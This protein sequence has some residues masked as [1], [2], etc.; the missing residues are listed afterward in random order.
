MM[1]PDRISTASGQESQGYICIRISSN[2]R[3][4]ISNLD[5]SNNLFETV[6]WKPE[7]DE[8]IPQENSDQ[9]QLISYVPPQP[10]YIRQLKIKPNP[11]KVKFSKSRTCCKNASWNFEDFYWT[12]EL[13]K[14]QLL[15]THQICV[16]WLVLLIKLHTCREVFNSS[17]KILELEIDNSCIDT[18]LKWSLVFHRSITIIDALKLD[19]ILILLDIYALELHLSV[20]SRWYNCIG[21]P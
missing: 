16:C 21:T 13:V 6:L 10:F 5:S 20:M 14:F 12:P 11:I 19:N 8:P 3:N 18:D 9:V 15:W 7:S 4:W 1:R 17:I 2:W